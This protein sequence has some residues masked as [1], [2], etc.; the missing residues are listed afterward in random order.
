MLKRGTVCRV[1]RDVTGFFHIGDIVVV[2]EN[3]VEVPH[4][5]LIEDYNPNYSLYDY[6]VDKYNPMIE[7][8]ELEE[9]YDWSEK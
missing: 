4:C 7:D 2:L 9:L 3:Y 8:Y 6:T 5:C 1:I